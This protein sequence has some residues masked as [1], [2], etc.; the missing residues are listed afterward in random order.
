METD[1]PFFNKS[2]KVGQLSLYMILRALV[3]FVYFLMKRP[4]MKHPDKCT[5]A[6]LG[7]S[8]SIHHSPLLL[9]IHVT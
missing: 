2:S 3:D 5:I 9:N 8:K 1:S 6:K 7:H 4:V